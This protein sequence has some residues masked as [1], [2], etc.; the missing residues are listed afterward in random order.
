MAAP[1]WGGA[2][3]A[4]GAGGRRGGIPEKPFIT[5]SARTQPR[6]RREW[7]RAASP[8]RPR[9]G[10]AGHTPAGHSPRGPGSGSGSPRERLRQFPAGPRGRSDVAGLHRQAAAV[11]AAAGPV[12]LEAPE[13]GGGRVGGGCAAAG[14]CPR[15][16]PR[17]L[18]T[19]KLFPLGPPATGRDWISFPSLPGR[20]FGKFLCK[21][22]FLYCWR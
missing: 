9:A 17:P 11:G 20:H 7:G 6:G 5:A 1:P 4:P 8:S 15:A 19:T 21:S 13:T 2:W 18:Y 14:G 12:G 3:A 22:L 16:A 10:E